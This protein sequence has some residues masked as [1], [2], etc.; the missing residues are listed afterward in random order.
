L[1]SEQLE[2]WLVPDQTYLRLYDREHQLRLTGEEAQAQRADI[3]AEQA[4]EA[5]EEAEEARKRAEM[6]AAKLRELGIN[7]DEL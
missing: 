5:R 4:E 6:F 7:P 2:S 3:Q 1:W